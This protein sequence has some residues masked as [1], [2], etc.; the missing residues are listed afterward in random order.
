MT[1]VLPIQVRWSDYDASGH[2]NNATFFAYLEQARM[3]MLA[4]FWVRRC[5]IQP[6]KSSGRSR[7]NTRRHSRWL[8]L[9]QRSDLAATSQNYAVLLRANRVLTCSVGKHRRNLAIGIT[10]ESFRLFWSVPLEFLRVT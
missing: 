8:N 9:R 6:T 4:G 2:V 10:W 1:Y 7:S 5:R 3:M